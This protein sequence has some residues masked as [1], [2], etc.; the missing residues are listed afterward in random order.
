MEFAGSVVHIRVL[1]MSV[2]WLVATVAALCLMAVSGTA[3]TGRDRGMPR[4]EAAHGEVA[5]VAKR[6]AADPGTLGAFVAAAQVSVVPPQRTRDASSPEVRTP[7]VVVE[8]PVP[9]SRGPPR[10]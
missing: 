3:R 2:R 7:R 4:F 6:A 9:A 10:G 1:A 5:V 8:Q